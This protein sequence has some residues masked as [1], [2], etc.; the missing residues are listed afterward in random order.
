MMH[1]IT[2]LGGHKVARQVTN[3]EDFLALRNSATNLSNLSRA[4]QGDA[5]AK[6]QLVQFA[7]NDMMPDGKVAG[8]CHPSDCFF[9]DI[10]CYDAA[11]TEQ[12][13]ALILSKKDEIGLLMLE[14]SVGGGWHLVCRRQLG[15]TILENQVRIASILKIEMDTNCHDLGRVVYSTSGSTDDLVYLDDAIF[16][17]T[18]C[19]E[20]SERE[21]QL[22]T[23]ARGP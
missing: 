16:E 23:R 22:G 7:Y 5:E 6:A 18:I 3:R 11:Q 4:R 10:D 1:Y 17:S 2:I 8:C 15:K 9:H 21:Y 14:R 20:D 12:Y 13:K 19:I